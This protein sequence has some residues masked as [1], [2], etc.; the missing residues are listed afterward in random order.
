VCLIVTDFFLYTGRMYLEVSSEV[1]NSF[2][3]KDMITTTL[4]S[5]FDRTGF[6]FTSTRDAPLSSSRNMQINNHLQVVFQFQRLCWVVT[7]SPSRHE[8]F[9]FL[10]FWQS[11]SPM[12]QSHPLENVRVLNH[13]KT[14][15]ISD[16]I[17]HLSV[18]IIIVLCYTGM[19][20]E[21]VYCQ[22]A[23]YC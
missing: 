13:R 20:S 5:Q 18:N 12:R 11:I 4:P 3:T 16:G 10:F 2:R 21:L 23:Q 7:G 15:G 14:C 22:N 1:V 8:S 19:S 17:P 9:S 6:L